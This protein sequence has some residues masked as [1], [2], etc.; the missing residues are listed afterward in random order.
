[1]ARPRTPSK[2][3]IY[4]PLYSVAYLERRYDRYY[5]VLKG[6]RTNTEL[7]WKPENKAQALK[8]LEELVLK[9]LNP[10]TAPTVQVIKTVE[11]ALQKWVAL[12]KQRVEKDTMRKTRN[13]FNTLLPD[14]AFDLNDVE[15]V[16]DE[17]LKNL[18][19][20]SS[21]APNTKHKYLKTVKQFFAFCV[22][23]GYCERNPIKK[24]MFPKQAP[25]QR[26]AFTH[27]EMAAILRYFTEKA[28]KKD[29]K[30]FILLLR[31]LA[32]TGVRISEALSIEWQDV[33]EK[34]IL[35]RHGKGGSQREIPIAPF[36][37]LQNVIDDLADFQGARGGKLFYWKAYAKLELWLRN[38][39][40]ELEIPGEGRN[41]HAIRK[42]FE[43]RML[44]EMKLPAH[45]VAQIIG[46]SVAVQQ[47][48]YL[49]ALSVAEMEKTIEN[50]T[51]KT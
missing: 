46:H 51:K 41:F 18:A 43:N 31:F 2:N 21:L 38:G 29:K 42:M 17:L 1:M 12:Q 34:R 11:D 23:E 14:V 36:P 19:S 20:A 45:I 15:S 49:K 5:V 24:T 40:R 33:N 37:E 48:Y 30:L 25:V 7:D 8:I 44:N 35:I 3:R 39:L 4:H 27:D 9:Y 28:T 10:Q 50:F 6:K 32:W 22:E 16:R 13:A 47:K 26:D